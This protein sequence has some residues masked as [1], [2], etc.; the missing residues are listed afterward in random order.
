MQ[1]FFC[2]LFSFIVC[3]SFNL[4]TFSPDNKTPQS[5]KKGVLHAGAFG[6][7][8]LSVENYHLNFKTNTQGFLP[9]LFSPSLSFPLLPSL[10]PFS[11]KPSAVFEMMN[12][13]IPYL[14]ETS[15]KNDNRGLV[16]TS[17]ALTHS[18]THSL[19]H[20]LPPSF[21]P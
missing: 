5:Q 16:D 18:L 7:D 17:D 11:P 12:T 4:F 2:F 21:P 14:K 13:S 9:S 19:T 3:L 1:V 15:E 6:S 20:L 8:S 10:F